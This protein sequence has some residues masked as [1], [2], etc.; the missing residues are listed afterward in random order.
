MILYKYFPPDRIDV[1]KNGTIRFTQLAALNDPFDCR[2]RFLKAAELSTSSSADDCCRD[3]HVQGLQEA[4]MMH[5]RQS[6][7]IVCLTEKP[8]NLLMW[9]HYAQNHEGFV[10][11]FD[12]EH[13]FFSKSSSGLG[14]RKVKYSE[15]RP[16]LPKRM[17]EEE[18]L[19]Q[20]PINPFGFVSIFGFSSNNKFG[21][22]YADG[23]DF[24]FV[25]S[26]DWGYEEEWRLVRNIS[27]PYSV[28]D[29][30]CSFPVYL[31]PFPRLSVHSVII[32][33]RGFSTIYPK[34]SHILNGHPDYSGVK[35]FRSK[36][37][38][39]RFCINLEPFIQEDEPFLADGSFV[40]IDEESIKRTKSNTSVADEEKVFLK[41]IIYS[42]RKE[43][44]ETNKEEAALSRE[45]YDAALKK[46]YEYVGE[47]ADEM[48][49]Q[50]AISEGFRDV[51]SDVQSVEQGFDLLESVLS[52]NIPEDIRAVFD[53]IIELSPSRAEGQFLLGKFM[54]SMGLS[55]H[56]KIFFEDAIKEDPSHVKSHHNLGMTYLEL[57]ETWLAE[58]AFHS[59]LQYDSKFARAR[60]NI[61]TICLQEGRT[62]AAKFY[63]KK[64]IEDDP[65]L[66][67]AHLNMIT[68]FLN[69]ND[70]DA[71][72]DE[73]LL[74]MN[75]DDI[76]DSSLMF[77]ANMLNIIP[78]SLESHKML[79]CN[80]LN[81]L[82][83]VAA[84]DRFVS[85]LRLLDFDRLALP[86][87]SKMMDISSD[88][89]RCFLHLAG[90]NKNLGEHSL[91]CKYLDKVKELVNPESITD[92]ACIAS[93]AGE[94]DQAFEYLHRAQADKTLDM[95][96]ILFEPSLTWIC[97]DDR[98][99]ALVEGIRRTFGRP[100][101]IQE[102]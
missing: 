49:N 55:Q 6:I 60:V 46:A 35:V 51:V 40:A 81:L 41:D 7:G 34:L 8:D 10:V 25:K 90:I 50:T 30:N 65:D 67:E 100:L 68:I 39:E 91:Y 14:L 44:D 47:A 66:V 20:P 2:P 101:P 4:L 94:T 74:T 24:R 12:T 87:L 59:A 26:R 37:D 77:A 71:A 73:L 78:E 72:I 42:G 85:I 16:S 89:F 45:E 36:T 38:G 53:R 17:V 22:E 57:G 23:D 58:A 92:L 102:G 63:F 29:A 11:G 3:A 61:G 28:I 99:A 56:G 98:F 13:P 43:N 83:D 93:I 79:Q 69:E 9:A 86:F 5:E 1:L 18:M 70:Y 97:H 48:L 21:Y 15:K 80:L 88:N 31:F 75:V 33:C 54:C 19:E 62:D 64:S 84:L 27:P 96:W 32:G 52:Q 95:R 76:P 82:Q